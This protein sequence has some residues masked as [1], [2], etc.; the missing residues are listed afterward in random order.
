MQFTLFAGLAFAVTK[1]HTAALT[2]VETRGDST[3]FLH[4]FLKCGHGLLIIMVEILIV[5]MTY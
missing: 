2:V 4:G 3:S 5:A 1:A